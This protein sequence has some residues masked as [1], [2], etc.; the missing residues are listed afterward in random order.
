M[1]G[2]PITFIVAFIVVLALIGVA[3]WLVRRFAGSR[4]GANTQRGRMPRLA[5]IDAAAVDGRRRLVLVRRDNVE[6][7]LMIGGP[8]DIVVEPNI[9]RAAP[10]RDQIPQRPSAAEPPRLAPMPDAGGWADEAPRPELLDHPEPQMPEPPPRPARPSFADEVR[11]PAPALA[12]RRSEPALGGFTPEPIAPRPEREPRP[13]PLPPRIARGE[14]PLMPRPPRGSEPM[15]MPPVRAE[16]AAAPP[17]P[18]PVPQAAPVPPPAA[19]AAPSSAEQNLAEMAQRLE[20]ALRRP[21][22]ETVAPPVAPEPPPAPA[23]AARS[24]PPAPPAAPAKPAAE[25]TS[26]EN[27]EDEMASLLG[28]PKPSS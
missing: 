28:R 26:F 15:K 1:Q 18:P 19:A 27:L 10:S 12:E 23:R 7:L 24:E 13:E 25:K 2:S 6:H 20:A 16:R 11:R 4:I 8:T 3:A 21:A 9:V 5:V 22:G 17:P 14:P